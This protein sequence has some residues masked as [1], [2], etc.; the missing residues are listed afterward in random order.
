LLFQGSASA[1]S[2]SNS[3][4]YAFSSSTATFTKNSGTAFTLSLIQGDY[5]RDRTINSG[6]YGVWRQNYGSAVAAPFNGADGNG[7]SIVDAGD[8]VLWRHAATAGS[9]TGADQ[10]GGMMGTVPEPGTILSAILLFL[11]AG[12][13]CHRSSLRRQ[14]V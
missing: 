9:G 5:L 3:A 2:T 10:M 1:G 11:G 13:L 4:D 12:L 14:E 8:Y 7:N 6:D